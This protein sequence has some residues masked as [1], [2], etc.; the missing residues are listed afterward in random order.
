[1]VGQTIGHYRVL[2]KL[3]AGGMGEVYRAEDTTLKREVALKVLPEGLSS[4]QDRL[5]RFQREAETLAALDHPNIV[6]IYSIEEADQVRF[7]TMQLVEGK[8]LG[9]EI[10]ENGMSVRRIFE[11]AVPLADA[12][13]AAHE[14]GVV[15]RD[16][17]PANI[18]IGADGGVKILDFGLAKLALE[19][20]AAVDT[21]LPTEPLTDEGKVLGTIP[22]M[23]P[24]QLAGETIDTRTDIFSLGVVLYEMATGQRPF[25]GDKSVSVIS[26]IMRDTPE[27]VDALRQDLP[28]H[29]GR[30]VAHCLEKDREQRYQSAK[31]VRNELQGLRREL[32]SGTAR[33]GPQVQP[34]NGS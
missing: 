33:S 10:P 3:G 18:M 32:E 22:Y 28:H 25:K 23:S 5:D 1:M 12:L 24:E 14:K 7:L 27:D 16:L 15:H 9:E 2:E 13:S 29:L 11:L 17:K 30:I 4:S 19:S 21:E 34:T 8:R 26:S 6:H 31:D 20:E